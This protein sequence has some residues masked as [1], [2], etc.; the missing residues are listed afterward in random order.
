MMFKLGCAIWAYKGWLG[1]L[2]PA[3][4]PASQFLPLY[5][6]RFTTVEVNATF[7]A[8]PS[9]ETVARWRQ[10]TPPGFEFCPKLPR[11]ITHEGPLQP[12]IDEA[13]RF[14]ALMQGL[15]D[16]LGP[17]FAQLPP[18][19][20][21]DARQDL[22][23]F[24]QGVSGCGLDLAVEVRHP[25]WFAL[26]QAGLLNQLLEAQGIGRVLLDTR[27]I[28][29]CNDNPQVASERR[30][31]QLPLQPVTTAPFSVIRYISHPDRAF[32]RPFMT[33]WVA[34]VKDWLQRDTRVYCFVH[35][36]VEEQSPQNAR[37]LQQLL[38][39]GGVPVPELPW[40]HLPAE[41]TQLK[42]F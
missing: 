39:E 10:D 31:P 41:P 33:D 35:C 11:S 18:T 40:D 7:Y 14:I 23:A 36:P 27:P 3:R 2:Y 20:G 28:Y 37:Y 17:I 5:G 1:D 24:L 32:N 4:S 9:P 6:Q 13:L 29:E 30:K 38:N 42:L 12:K 21:P 16:R 26:P 15:G 19:Y 34:D 22:A 8:V 25:Q